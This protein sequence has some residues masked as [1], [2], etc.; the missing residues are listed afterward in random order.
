MGKKC[1]YCGAPYIS[2]GGSG[3]LVEEAPYCECHLERDIADFKAKNGKNYENHCWNCEAKIDSRICKRDPEPQY[4]YICIKC[5][6]SL[7]NYKK[8]AI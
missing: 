3:D 5:G 8:M 1:E 7:R 6:E 4:G 2:V